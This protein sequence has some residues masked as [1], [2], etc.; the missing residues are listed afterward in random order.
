MV[1]PG[2]TNFLGTAMAEESTPARKREGYGDYLDPSIE[3]TRMPRL[4][5]PY[6]VSHIDLGDRCS[7]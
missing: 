6:M 4:D 3:W 7:A 5:N 1:V 2:N